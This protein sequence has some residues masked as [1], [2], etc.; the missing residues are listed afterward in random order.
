MPL[1]IT[2]PATAAALAA[3][4]AIDEVRGPDGQLL[5][6]FIPAPRPGLE[7]PEFGMSSAQMRMLADDPNTKWVPAA[8]VEARLRELRRPD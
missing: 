5:G 1:T 4:T 8:E 6:R 3:A 2:D 7:F